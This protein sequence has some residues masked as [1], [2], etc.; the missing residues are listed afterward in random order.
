M[1]DIHF[2]PAWLRDTFVQP[3]QG[4]EHGGGGP[5][6]G[7][8]GGNDQQ[9]GGNGGKMASNLNIMAPA[10][11]AEFRYGREEMLA[12]FTLPD[13][14]DSPLRL[15][16]EYVIKKAGLLV[17]RPDIPLNLSR[18]MSEEEQRAWQ[19]G[20]NSDTSLRLYRKE[21]PPGSMPGGPGMGRG[22]PGERGRGRG[23]GGSGY[24]DRQRPPVQDEEDGGATPGNRREESERGRGFG[25]GN[26]EFQSKTGILT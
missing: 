5:T 20:A 19:K 24:F 17:D 23:R 1:T 4:S 14:Y 9:R 7:G 3:P 6:N 22:A 10:K 26:S 15:Y 8:G 12:L 25:R 18:S 16:Q 13:E 11:L 2:G 21:M